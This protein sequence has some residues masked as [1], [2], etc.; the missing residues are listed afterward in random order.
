MEGAKEMFLRMREVD[1]IEL[2]PDIR[3]RFTYCEVREVNE[4]E[5]HKDDPIYMKLYQDKR[6]AAKKVQEYLFEKRHK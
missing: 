6:R 1:F 4:Y 3:E 5:N 2:P